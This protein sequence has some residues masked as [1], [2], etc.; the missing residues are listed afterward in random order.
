MKIFL[1]KPNAM[2]FFSLTLLAAILLVQNPLM[3]QEDTVAT[4]PEMEAVEEQ[5][6]QTISYLDRN[7]NFGLKAGLNI[8]TFNDAEVYN[9]DTQ[10]RLH[11]GVFSRYRFTE[12]LSA[13]AE[14]LYSMKG[15]RAD[16]FSIFE[17]HSVDLNYLTLPV[18]AEFALTRKVT[19]ELGPYIGV[20][21]GARQS[22]DELELARE[23]VD[24]TEDDTNFVDVGIG[25][26][27]TYTG[28]NGVGIGLRYSQGLAD[29]LGDDFF[30]SASGSNSVIQISGYYHF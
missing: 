25:G 6:D 30:R 16:E 9:A 28:S 7:F 19:L 3:A 23:S 11:L 21:L 22:F 13:K 20:L 17:E 29:A 15:A 12:R 24:L 14:L 10:T 27:L 4:S 26:G 8:S 5:V 18:M 2:K 1:L